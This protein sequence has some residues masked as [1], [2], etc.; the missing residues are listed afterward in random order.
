APNVT[1]V[2]GESGSFEMP[3]FE[4][5]AGGIPFL[6]SFSIPECSDNKDAAWEF[7]RWFMEEENQK[8]NLLE[9]EGVYVPVNKDLLDW[10]AN[11]GVLPLGVADAVRN[12]QAYDITP[13]T[14]VIRNVILPP[15]IESMFQ[16]QLAPEE[17]AR[18]SGEQAQQELEDAGVAP[19]S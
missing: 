5:G 12:A 17:Y 8:Q 4:P 9:G 14:G 15:L 1:S 6:W 13:A 2:I 16:G 18:V 7:V 11:E 19:T 10:A 3:S